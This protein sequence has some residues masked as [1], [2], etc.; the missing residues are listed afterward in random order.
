MFSEQGKWANRIDCDSMY[1]IACIS[2]I[3]PAVMRE[4]RVSVFSEQGK[5]ANRIG[6]VSVHSVVIC[7]SSL[8]P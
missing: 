2:A 6:C 5:W 1:S 7:N 4:S 8:Q 3:A